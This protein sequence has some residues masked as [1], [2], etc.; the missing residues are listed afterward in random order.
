MA[1]AVRLT[2]LVNSTILQIIHKILRRMT[3]VGSV[4]VD[5]KN[6][7]RMRINLKW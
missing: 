4:H 6:L 1:I 2:L 5:E 3:C 7:S